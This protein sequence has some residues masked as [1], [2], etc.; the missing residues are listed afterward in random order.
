M[1]FI[2]IILGG[3][4]LE[5]HLKKVLIYCRESRDDYF[6]NY[7][8]INNQKEI[9]IDFCKKEGYENI[10]DIV[11]DDNV[12]GTDFERFKN[13]IKMCCDKK[14]DTIVFKDS[15]RLGRNLRQTLNFINLLEK[16]NISVVF[17]S[18]EYNEDF[19]PLKAWFNEQRAK[20][21]SIKI[22]NLF[23]YKMQNG[24]LLI[25]ATY[26]YYKIDNRLEID[27]NT[28]NTVKNIYKWFLEGFSTGEIALKLNILNVMTPSQYSNLKNKS[29]AWNKQHITRILK[30]ELYT[31]TMIYSKVYKESYKN[32]K[33][34]HR[35][36]EDWIKIKNHHES[37]ISYEDYNKVQKM[38][39]KNKVLKIR[40]KINNPFSGI[41]KC[42]RCGSNLIAKKRNNKIIYYICSKNQ[43]EGTV[44]DNIRLNYGCKSHYIK[45]NDIYKIISEYI[46]KLI[47][48][49]R[50]K[51]DNFIN[52]EFNDEKNENNKIELFERKINNLNSIIDKIYDD[53]LNG[54][55]D[56]DLF[57]NKY[58]EYRNKIECVKEELN[59]LF[60][61][62]KNSLNKIYNY[63]DIKKIYINETEKIINSQIIKMVFESIIIFLPNEINENY[64]QIYNINNEEFEII[65]KDGGIIL[66]TNY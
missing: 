37:I 41:L 2:L 66:I 48:E 44:K 54:K 65:K 52:C 24:T 19:F 22:R 33:Y 6:K 9:L 5:N 8:R 30:N 1:I 15:S 11:M 20:E 49:N 51:I 17:Q 28:A 29:S 42:G 40:N 26:G 38:F 55:I 61:N 56:N 13:I 60:Q 35:K 3:G 39:R 23:K 59:I 27:E 31:G 57:L 4:F 58:N 36:E 32:K 21:D 45:Q 43:K 63:E 12:T 46:L 25:R 64:K 14:I 50:K 47:D 62:K 7:A 34:I 10:I 18:E 53:N 16:L